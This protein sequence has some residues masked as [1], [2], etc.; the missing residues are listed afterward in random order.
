M[1]NRERSF[2]D[3][4]GGATLDQL[5]RREERDVVFEQVR[6]ELKARTCRGQAVLLSDCWDR[7]VELCETH[8]LDIPTYFTSRRIF[9]T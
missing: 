8:S 2:C 3:S 7:F 1:R 9:E 5:P 6:R 4:N